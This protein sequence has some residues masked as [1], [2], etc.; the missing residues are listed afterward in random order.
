MRKEKDHACK[1]NGP[2]LAAANLCGAGRLS[3]GASL[4]A[5]EAARF[6]EQAEGLKEFLRPDVYP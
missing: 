3:C 5:E 2:D 6:L 4:G 1:H